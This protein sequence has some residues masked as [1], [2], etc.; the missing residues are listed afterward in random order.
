MIAGS[1]TDLASS[2]PKQVSMTDFRRLQCFV[3]VAEEL[4]FG[5]AA[6]RLHISQPPLTRQIQCLE[7][8]LGVTL[9]LRNA[10]RVE[11]T[12]AGAA[13]LT[14]A[15]KLLTQVERAAEIARRTAN[16]KA[17]RLRLLHSGSVMYC[18]RMPT[19]FAGL[20][21]IK[22]DLK[23]IE[24]PTL[25]QYDAL[26]RGTADL[27]FNAPFEID[28]PA[29]IHSRLLFREPLMICRRKGEAAAKPANLAQ[30]AS[31]PLVL[32]APEL[33]AGLY[34]RVLRLFREAGVRPDRM[35]EVTQFGAIP[36]LVASGAGIAVVP[37]SAARMRWPGLEFVPLAEPAHFDV[38]VAWTEGTPKAILDILASVR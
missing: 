11:L 30:L 7:D 16:G 32:Y 14:E 31:Q 22:V 21:T 35:I 23:F 3:V 10:K 6:E 25:A 24:A 15:R 1:N 17:A 5:R 2:S 36:T 34:N 20:W 28:P 9:L 26:L 8:E 29:G 37:A 13:Y 38:H 4:H 18:D 27:G 33:K 12:E 19:I